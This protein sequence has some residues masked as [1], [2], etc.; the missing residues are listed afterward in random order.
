[1]G[2]ESYGRLGDAHAEGDGGDDHHIL[3]TDEGG[4]V[5]RPNAG[6]ETGMVGKHLAPGSAELLGQLL[7]LVTAGRVDDAR[8]MLLAEQSLQL[9]RDA[10]ARPNVVAD[11]GPV[12][13]GDDQAVGRDAE[14]R[15]STRLNSSH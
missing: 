10:V 7:G 15:K 3:R 9:L 4:L 12:E 13:S 8:P 1:M 14:D 5:A 11:I 2:D 6:I